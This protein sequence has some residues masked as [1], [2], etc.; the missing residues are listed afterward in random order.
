MPAQCSFV[1]LRCVH[2]ALEGHA[3]SNK[4]DED[5]VTDFGFYVL[6]ALLLFVIGAF[7]YATYR[8]LT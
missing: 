2:V 1:L 5:M 7:L 3:M 4:H 6:V 8:V